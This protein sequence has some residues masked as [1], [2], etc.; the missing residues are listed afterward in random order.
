MGGSG[1]SS[2]SSGDG[3]R[4]ISGI[5]GGGGNDGGGGSSSGGSG[6]GT[7][8]NEKINFLLKTMYCLYDTIYCIKYSYLVLDTI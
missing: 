2:C 8:L 3:G 5:V 1:G 6:I 7:V 4:S